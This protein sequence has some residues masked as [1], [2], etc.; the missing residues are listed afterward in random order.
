MIMRSPRSFCRGLMI[1]LVEGQ[2]FGA[3]CDLARDRG[4]TEASVAGY[5]MRWCEDGLLAE[6]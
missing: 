6:A 5:L 4:T 3:M 2:S 1:L